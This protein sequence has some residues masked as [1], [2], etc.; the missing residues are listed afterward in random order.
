MALDSLGPVM[1]APRRTGGRAGWLLG[2][3][4]VVVPLMAVIAARLDRLVVTSDSVAQQSVVVTWFRAGHATTYLPPDT[5]LLKIPVYLGVEA[6]PLTPSTRLLVESVTLAV[7]AFALLA[8]GLGLIVRSAGPVGAGLRPVDV[9]LPLAWLGTVGGGLGQYLAVMPNSRNLELGAAF[10]LLGAVALRTTARGA[11]RSAARDVAAAGAAVVVLGL[12]WVDDPYVAFLVGLPLAVACVAWFML[13]DRDRRLLGAAAVLVVSLAAL[14]VLR[15]VLALAGV[16]VVPDATGVTLDPA[17]LVAHLPILWP[18][19]AAQVGLR[20]PATL[21]SWP[22]RVTVLVVLAVGVVAGGWLARYGWRERA[23]G[24]AFLGVHWLVVVAGVLVNRTIY[25]FHAG[26]Y[27]VLGIVDLAVTLGVTTALL[28]RT[29]PRLAAGIGVL[30]AVAALADVVAVAG[31]RT[32][33]PVLAERQDRTLALL[34]G[35]GATK[36]VSGFWAADL[37]THRSGGEL[38]LSDVGCTGHRL[39][40][41]FWL[42]DSARLRLPAARSVVLW[43]ETAPDGVGCSVADLERQF[44]PPVERLAAPT[45]GVVLVYDD[46]VT[47]RLVS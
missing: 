23:L 12:L 17:R 41:R 40:A 19:L 4:V 36:G 2:A 38:L 5:W 10:C 25:D 11:D 3:A 33:L 24:P 20:E 9:V 16:E 6:L 43:D 29:R 34:R 31:D 1:H 42:T 30:L 32:Q 18:S 22:A 28:R 37:Y 14:P 47:T 35:T 44:G 15:R 21:A 26:R 8:V 7:L 39:R 27:L 46:D 13:R 45:G